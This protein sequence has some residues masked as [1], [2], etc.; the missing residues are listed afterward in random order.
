MYRL[1]ICL[2]LIS[3]SKKNDTVPVTP[4][5]PVPPPVVKTT[6]KLMTLPA[7]WKFSVNLSN[8]FPDAIE[9]YEFDSLVQG[10]KVKAFAVAFNPK[11]SSIEF[12]PVLSATSRKPSDFYTQ[13][14]GIV[15][16]CIN[17][18]FFGGNQSYS[19]VKYNN[20]V[21]AANIKSVS[22]TYNGLSTPYFPTRAA[23]GINA[24]G[25][26]STAW[27]YHV[28]TGNNRV[29]QY[30]LPSPNLVGTQPRQQPDENF[31]AGGSEWQVNSAIGGSPMLLKAGTISITDKEELIDINNT[32]S[33]PRSAIGATTAGLVL[34]VAIEGDNPSGGY[35]G[36]NLADLARMLKDLGCRDAIN[37][38]GGG[39]TSFIV[40]NRQ[41]VR[42]GD[43]GVERVVPTVVIIKKK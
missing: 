38:D 41:T 16:A 1:L 5:P 40:N 3:C 14:Q 26:P 28:G 20:S 13:E 24:T 8:G 11:N 18:G 25:D 36:V 4:L 12:K 2:L 19:L 7:G 17:G 35:A 33:R 43:N 29:F 27:V 10:T 30:P 21:L 22:R 31:P 6:A 32:T 39:S 34:L 9:A 37:L 42:P 15:Y 23:F